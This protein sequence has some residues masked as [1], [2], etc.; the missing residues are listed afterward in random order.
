MKARIGFASFT[1]ALLMAVCAVA[2]PGASRSASALQAS[3][4]AS[5]TAAETI[6][7]TGLVENPSRFTVADLQNLTAQRVDVTFQAVGG[8]QKHTYTGVRLW[9]VLDRAKLKLNPAHKNDQLRKYV[10][11]TAKD[12]YEVLISLGE[13]DPDFGHQ[14]YL[15]AWEEDGEPLTGDNGPAR[16]VTPGDLKGGRYEYG[17]VKIEVRDVDSPPR[18]PGNG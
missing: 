2:A 9:D 12:G 7:L 17:V 4:E 3:P 18:A 11:L 1:L 13:I 16:L 10:V 8:K 14:P 5:P 6:E 15:L